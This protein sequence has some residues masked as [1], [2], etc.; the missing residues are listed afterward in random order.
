VLVLVVF[1]NV[2][3]KAVF[4]VGVRDVDLVVIVSL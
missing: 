1:I 2:D 3:I 4:E